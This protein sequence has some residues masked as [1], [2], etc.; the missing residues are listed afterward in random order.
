MTARVSAT[1]GLLLALARA[2]SAV[3]GGNCL[4]VNDASDTT[5]ASCDF[6]GVGTCSLRDAIAKSQAIQGWSIQFAIGAGHQTISPM[7]NFL[8]IITRGTID[9]TTQ[10]GY[11]GAPLIEIHRADAGTAGHALHVTADGLVTVR[12]LIVNNFAGSCPD[13]F[14]IG[15]DSPGQ[16][17]VEGCYIGTDA[18]GTVAV[19]NS[20]G[21]FVNTG[22]GGNTIGGTTAAKRNVISSNGTGIGIRIT[23]STDNYIQGN[24]IGTDAT[25]TLPLPNSVGVSIADGVM[26]F[27]NHNHVGGPTAA[28]RN[29]F[30]GDPLSTTGVVIVRGSDDVIEGN[31]FGT[32]VTGMQA[33][34]QE[35]AIR[36]DASVN[37]TVSAN[38]VVASGVGISFGTDGFSRTQG[39][40]IQGNF[41]GTDVTGN[42]VL[43]AGTTGISLGAAQNNT[44]GGSVA[45]QG[46]VIGGFVSGI[47][48]GSSTSTGNAIL[49]NRIG[50]GVNGSPIPNTV[51]G[52]S[53]NNGPTTI[54]GVNP[55]EGNIIAFNGIAS[56]APVPGI[57]VTNLFSY[58][59]RGNSIFGNNGKGID[60]DFPYGV[61]PHAN[62]AGDGDTGPNG[63]QNFPMITNVAFPQGGG[64]EIAGTLSSKPSTNY[65]LDFYANPS[66]LHPKDFLQGQTWIGFLPVTTDSQGKVA[67]DQLFASVSVPSSS[68]ISATAT[69]PGG[70]TSEFSQ[71][72][73]FSVAPT[74]GPAAPA[75]ARLPETANAV[76]LRGQLFQ[77]GATVKFGPSLGS[78]VNV[79][80]PT[81]ITASTPTLPA[82]NLLDVTVTNPDSSSATMQKAWL[83]DFL[84]VPAGS[85]F[86]S[87]VTSLAA[88]GVTGGCG[89][90]NYCPSSNVTRAQMAVFLLKGKYGP[91]YLPPTATG[92]VFGDVPSGSF[93]AAWIEELFHEGITGGCG[94]GNYCPGSSVT[95]QQMA[96]FLLK[97]EHG[98]SYVPPACAGIFGDVAC[99]GTFAN[100]IERLYAEQVTGG[101]SSNPLLYCPTANVTRGQMAV[102]IVKTFRLP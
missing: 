63:L 60:F 29:I 91:W 65:T 49:G 71:R 37:E 98:S 23:A 97:S 30:G 51:V 50:I 83:V 101:C 22:V 11:A 57:S 74:H 72:G 2:A 102:F 4:L 10:P 93:A 34:A 77:N 79:V 95:R 56:P 26:G 66:P 32:D 21:I 39:S 36:V 78:N 69:D 35:H 18:T 24:Y 33:I 76:T 61:L 1:A 87:W 40:T 55:G 82:G 62:D 42:V 44:V 99:P 19:P 92:T 8:D 9:G 80:D 31:Y 48:V 75:G 86:Y 94:G 81:L 54:G 28:E 13:C 17:F 59:I 47:V 84:D 16:N 89:G 68:W 96:V 5:H 88:D 38:L 15:F 7:S 100:W 70:N 90:G 46:N 6:G 27:T 3:C 20:T 41:V 45:G 67:F 14:G 52:I 12:A 43:Y 73:L 53:A 25:G 85:T 58:T 64:V